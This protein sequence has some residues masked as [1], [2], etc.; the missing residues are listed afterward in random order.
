MLEG[1]QQ[2]HPGRRQPAN[3]KQRT[4]LAPKMPTSTYLFSLSHILLSTPDQPQEVQ[5]KK[6]I[7]LHNLSRVGHFHEKQSHAWDCS[8]GSD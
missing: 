3:A 4:S 8:H 2:L 1:R 6:T 7:W 5:V